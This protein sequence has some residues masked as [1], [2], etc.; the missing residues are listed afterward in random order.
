MSKLTRDE[1]IE[2]EGVCVH[3]FRDSGV[4]W[5]AIRNMDTS[6]FWDWFREGWVSSLSSATTYDLRGDCL[7][8]ALTV[9][10][11][12]CESEDW[13]LARKRAIA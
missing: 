12:D 11:A 10:L 6:D 5:Y 13:V 4:L 3:P 9:A 1:K 7:N 8:D 2:L